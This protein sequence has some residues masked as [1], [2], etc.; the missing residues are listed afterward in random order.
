VT[1]AD[2]ITNHEPW[3]PDAL[4]G[5]QA[6]GAELNAL[7]DE[8]LEL[9][10][11]RAAAE[12][13]ERF[14]VGAIPALGSPGLADLSLRHRCRVGVWAVHIERP[15]TLAELNRRADGHAEVCR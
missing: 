8:L 14:E 9:R 15:L 7:R 1:L 5:M 13:R 3:N 6:T 2:Q 11:L 4:A 12:V 10:R